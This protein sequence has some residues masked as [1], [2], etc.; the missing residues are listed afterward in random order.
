[1]ERGFECDADMAFLINFPT[2]V[3]VHR[4]KRP[5]V[6][7]GPTKS[8]VSYRCPL[9]IPLMSLGAYIRIRD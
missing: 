2:R 9:V 4:V 7:P 1:M 6:T 3:M 8:E 5:A